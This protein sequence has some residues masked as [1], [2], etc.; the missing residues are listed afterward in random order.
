MGMFRL[1]WGFFE[2]SIALAEVL[3]KHNRTL[4]ELRL[5]GNSLRDEG[6]CAL[7]KVFFCF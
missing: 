4:V 1:I 3:E 6:A 5:T 2:G 7:A